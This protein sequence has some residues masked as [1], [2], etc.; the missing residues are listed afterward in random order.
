MHNKVL[1]TGGAGFVGANL[2]LYLSESGYEVT[3]LDNLVRRGSEY[4]IER[5]KNNGV[6]FIHGDIRNKED[7]VGIRADVVLECAAQ[8]SAIDGYNNPRYDFTNN[9]FAVMNLLEFCREQGA[10]LIFWSTNKVYPLSSIMK[11][12]IIEM[13]DR[14]VSDH[15]IDEN[16]PLDGGDRSLYGCSKVMADLMI[17]EW[18]DAFDIPAVINRF[19][20]LA[21]PWQWGKSEQG[22]VSWWIIAHRLGLPLQYIGFRGKQVRDVLF[23]PDLCRLI[24][25]QIETITPGAKVY[26]VGGSHY[27]SMSLVECTQIAQKIT[28]NVVPISYTLEARRADFPVYIS[29]TTKLEREL[30]W[31]PKVF[32]EE[33][34]EQIDRWVVDNIDLLA[35]LNNVDMPQQDKAI[36]SYGVA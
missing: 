36:V 3:A 8:P 10:G 19:S 14:L 25:R 27:S 12:R 6:T 26:N 33:G 23:I 2:A 11:G 21:G 34:M 24:E 32:I 30:G 5:L 13:Q 29:D 4:N 20:C 1:I 15:L 22:W 31:Y 9:T 18:A 17:Q 28:D 7:L 16:T 35:Q